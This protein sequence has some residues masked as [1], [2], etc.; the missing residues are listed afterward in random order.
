MAAAVV[1]A[2]VSIDEVDDDDS[3]ITS[4]DVLNRL[5]PPSLPSKTERGW[6][7]FPEWRW[8]LSVK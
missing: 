5:C 1:A 8:R 4:F 7:Y 2:A 6:R 3:C